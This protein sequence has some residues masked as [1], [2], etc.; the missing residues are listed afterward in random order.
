[1][2]HHVRVLPHDRVYAAERGTPLLTLLAENGYTVTAP[3][4]GTGKCGKC[5]V[6]IL[7][8]SVEGATP[9]AD[10]YVLACR[11]RITGD[12]TV[13]VSSQA[14]H[15]LDDF[16][17][18]LVGGKG[19]GVG[20]ILDIGTTT[21]A[22]CLVD[23]SD[24]RVLQKRTSLNPQSVLGA[25]VLS[26]IKACG[27]GKLPLLQRLMIDR[28]RA[29]LLDLNAPAD[30]PLFVAANTT[31]LHLFLG[32]DPSP[33]GVYPFTPVFT[34][35]QRKTG[36]TLGLPCGDVIT[37]P[38]VSGYVGGDVM[39]GVVACGMDQDK[40]T[41]LLVDV[42]TNGE[43]VL[44]H[45][46]KLFATSTAAGPALEGACIACGMGGVAGAI[47]S[48]RLEGDTLRMETVDNTPPRGIC[49]S[50]LI[51]LVACLVREELIE[52][53]GAW[54]EDCD[55]PLMERRRGDRFYLTDEVYLS[56]KDIRELQLAKSAIAAG[57]ETLLATCGVQESDVEEVLLAGGLGYYMNVASAAYLGLLP[58]AME[59][60]VRVVGN[61]ALAGARVC[62][63]DP[64]AM[65]ERIARA[66]ERVKVVELGSSPIFCDAYMRHMT[67]GEEDEEWS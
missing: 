17:D 49:G 67:L 37:L 31:M 55:S 51:D 39:A 7:N 53:T 2:T 45:D 6:R 11:A 40:R 10:G 38:S 54:S 15:G 32:V 29:L 44:S 56:Q 21:L 57:I 30:A 43:I 59:T 35:T 48:V 50:G 14:G 16:S 28:V 13:A 58:Q 3:C 36:K 60:R 18:A 19:Y 12:L 52:P 62:L 27:E 61:T 64:D 8:G 66:A 47:S 33:I 26:R 9:D 24:G 25:D 63:V 22:A 20:T 65:M 5:R 23:R 1:M 46:G 41:R 4:G 34:E 42:G